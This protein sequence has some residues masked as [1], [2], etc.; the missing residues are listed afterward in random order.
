MPQ[1]RRASLLVPLVIAA[2]CGAGDAAPATPP[3]TSPATAPS[4][5][6][7]LERDGALE[8]SDLRGTVSFID[9]YD[10]DV[11][12]GD[13]VRVTLTS[14]A[15]DPVLEVTPARGAPL[16]ND[17]VGGD[18]TRSELELVSPTAGQL[19]IQVTSFQRGAQGAYHVRVVRLPA[20]APVALSLIHI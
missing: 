4:N 16:T 1:L 6:V 13:R 17:D 20:Q 2:G 3:P 12:A 15:F 8:A 19:K 10:V 18:R 14:Q 7:L 11:Q 5:G 9:R